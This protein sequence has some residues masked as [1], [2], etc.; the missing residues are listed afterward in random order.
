MLGFVGCQQAILQPDRGGFLE[1]RNQVARF[2]LRGY[3]NGAAYRNGLAQHPSRNGSTGYPGSCRGQG[4]RQ[5]RACAPVGS[6]DPCGV[7]RGARPPAAAGP[8]GD[9]RGLRRRHGRGQGA[10]HGAP[11]R[12]RHRHRP[13]DRR[14]RRRGEGQGRVPRVQAHAT[15]GRAA[16]RTRRS[17]MLLTMRPKVLR[18][19]CPIATR[20]RIATAEFHRAGRPEGLDS[21]PPAGSCRH[22]VGWFCAKPG[23]IPR[24][25]DRQRFAAGISESDSTSRTRSAWRETPCRASMCFTCQR[26]VL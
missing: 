23:E 20:G 7:V 21:R 14:V 25:R 11:L 12:H 19:L 15:G 2:Q 9:G 24:R 5:H 4:P 6:C 13:P 18:I 3:R 1:E 22:P 16:G 10:G 26:M 8:P 17:G